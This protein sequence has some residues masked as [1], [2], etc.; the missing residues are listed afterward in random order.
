EF[1]QAVR[2]K[3]ARRHHRVDR[4]L[5]T[6]PDGAYPRICESEEG[7]HFDQIFAST[8]GRHL[9]RYLR[10]DDLPGTSDGCSEQTCG[11]FTRAGRSSLARPGEERQGEDGQDRKSTRLN[12][13]HE[14]I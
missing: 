10:R 11:L 12:S 2:R 13:S 9:R 5:P 7:Y 4:A 8:A 6:R 1:V 3:K 14:W